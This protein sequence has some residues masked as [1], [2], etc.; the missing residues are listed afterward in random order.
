MLD[1]DDDGAMD[2]DEFLRIESAG[3]LLDCLAQHEVLCSNV[4]A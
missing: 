3:E 4:Q 2:A 1:I